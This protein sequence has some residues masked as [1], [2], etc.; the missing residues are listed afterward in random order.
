M[1]YASGVDVMLGDEVLVQREGG[2][3]V[4]RV[5]QLVAAGTQ[6]ASDWSLPEGGCII[7]GG[8]LGLFAV[9]SLEG[10]PE[11]EFVRRGSPPPP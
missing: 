9:R 11:V 3:L 1:R 2:K 7:E 4:G 5:L 6:D 8:G 10:D